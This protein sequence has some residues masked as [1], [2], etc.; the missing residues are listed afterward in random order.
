MLGI[1]S[2][3]GLLISV[4]VGCYLYLVWASTPSIDRA[5]VQPYE[6]FMLY[7][8]HYD[9]V[10]APFLQAF[11]VASIFAVLLGASR[12][13]PRA[14]HS[15]KVWIPGIVFFFSIQVTI[16]N[17]VVNDMKA[18]N[19]LFG[20]YLTMSWFEPWLVNTLGRIGPGVTSTGGE[21]LAA[22]LIA[23]VALLAT[24]SARRPWDA[25]AETCLFASAALFFFELGILEYKSEWWNYEVSQVQSSVGLEWFSNK[26]LYTLA[27]L[28]IPFFAALRLALWTPGRQVGLRLL[29]RV[30]KLRS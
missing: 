20:V 15:W 23:A 30:R 11:R 1:V 14:A 29:S 9:W 4:L 10:A 27:T 24:R 6:N 26:M 3:V 13:L 5:L 16:F 18:D 22:F 21:A 19:W 25:L 2:L 8:D 28:C 17:A 12:L 7:Y